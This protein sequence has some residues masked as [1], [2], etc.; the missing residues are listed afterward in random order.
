MSNNTVKRFE[1]QFK[2]LRNN[3]IP[4][5]KLIG[6]ERRNGNSVDEKH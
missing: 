2:T 6:C 4:N 3:L 1:E 5:N